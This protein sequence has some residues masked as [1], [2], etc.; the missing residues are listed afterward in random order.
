MLEPSL[1]SKRGRRREA[2]Y[3]QGDRSGRGRGARQE[4]GK[5]HQATCEI[6]LASAW[7]LAG[8]ERRLN[9]APLPMI[10]LTTSGAPSEATRGEH[11]GSGARRNPEANP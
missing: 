10:G 9:K 1:L 3:G 7:T 4:R 8:Q 2:R 11:E 5:D 6:P